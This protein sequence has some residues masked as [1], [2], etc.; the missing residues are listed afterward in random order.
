MQSNN[1]YT[2]QLRNRLFLELS[3]RNL[4]IDDDEESTTD[5][6]VEMC[7][8]GDKEDHEQ[9]FSLFPNLPVELRLQIW[10]YAL[11]D[12]RILLLDAQFRQ[13][14]P[15]E[16]RNRP[17]GVQTKETTPFLSLRGACRESS[18]VFTKHYQHLTVSAP[19]Q[20]KLP[21]YYDEDDVEWTEIDVEALSYQYFDFK[22]DTILFEH[23]RSQTTRTNL[24]ETGFLT[25]KE[26]EEYDL[27]IESSKFRNLAVKFTLD[28]CKGDH[29]PL[30]Q[31]LRAVCPLLK[32]L[33]YVRYNGNT[34]VKVIREGHSLST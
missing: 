34:L 26:Y 1:D 5:S 10:K 17:G 12:P 14:G 33:N 4:E 6:D 31:E 27:W 22:A 32:P 7:D 20:T 19:Q 11:P 2:S 25:D 29:D 15:F 9:K 24:K 21:D 8:I 23:I 3:L 16:A 30:W 18:D 13:L 28:K